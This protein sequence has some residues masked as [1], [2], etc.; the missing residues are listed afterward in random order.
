MRRLV[1]LTAIAV[2]ALTA[3]AYAVADNVTYTA[4]MSHKGTPSTKKPGNLAYNGILHVESDPPGNQ[5]DTAPKTTVFFS[6]A[7]VNNSKYF[8]SCTQSEID[9]QPSIPTKCKKAIVGSGTASALAGT[10]GQ[11]AAQSIREDLKV[12]VMNGP[13]GKTLFL[14]L[15]AASPVQVQNAVVPGYLI[16]AS[17]QYGFAVRF[18]VPPTL[19]NNSGLDIALTDFNVKIPSTARK[20]KVGKVVKSISYLQVTSCKTALPSKAIAYFKDKDTG[21]ET[22]VTSE[23]TSAKC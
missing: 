10:P 12:T 15:N 17:G 14:V 5:P 9:G 8:P 22:P 3:V 11:P 6:K 20:L 23:Q 21:A 4:K 1:L 2:M 7:I 19:Q 16:K 18:E 13:K